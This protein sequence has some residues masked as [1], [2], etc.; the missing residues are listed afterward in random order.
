MNI[1][2]FGEKIRKARKEKGLTQR[3]LAKLINA[4]HNSISNW[5]NDQNKPDPDTIELICGVLD[6]TPS[7][8]MGFDK[9]DYYLSDYN[10]LLETNET[11]NNLSDFKTMLLKYAN[12]LNSLGEREALKR[13]EE[14]TFIPKYTKEVPAYLEPVAAH[15]RNDVEV[16]DEMKQND[17][18]LMNDDSIW[19]K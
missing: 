18:K 10:V 8:L 17:D 19:N 6:I 5:E 11:Y 15:E 14:L 16:T 12:K 4:K 7:Y 9:I 2:T 3:D 13:I 1:L